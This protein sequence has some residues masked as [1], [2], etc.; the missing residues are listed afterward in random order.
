M[1]MHQASTFFRN[2]IGKTILSQY[3]RSRLYKGL[4]IGIEKMK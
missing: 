2:D 1:E 4:A 3:M